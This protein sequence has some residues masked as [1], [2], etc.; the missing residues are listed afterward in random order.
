VRSWDV[1]VA[2]AHLD[3]SGGEIRD[4]IRSTNSNH[5][6]FGSAPGQQTIHDDST[7]GP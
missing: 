1:I 7:E 4:T 5:H 3:P 6:L 2:T